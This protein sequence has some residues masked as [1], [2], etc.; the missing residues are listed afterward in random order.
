[1]ESRIFVLFLI[2]AVSLTTGCSRNKVV[3][4]SA[5][6]TVP[7][8]NPE[9]ARRDIKEPR[10]DTENFEIGAYVGYKSVEDFESNMVWGAKLAYHVSEHIFVEGTYG[11][12]DVGETSFEKLS[13]GAPLLT[14]DE[15]TMKY[16]DVSLGLNILPGE[17]FIGRSLAFNS[18]LYIVGGVGNTE[19]AGD[20]F[21]TVVFGAGYRVLAT[22]WLALNF[23]VRDHMFDSD[24]LGE[25]K[26]THNIEF[27][28]GLTLFF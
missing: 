5:D 9:V 22:D 8:I 21:F 4:N 1:M 12:T 15:R 19:F 2:V 16:Y 24:L 28:L 18:A 17:V 23:L 13:G 20:D 3:D 7:V 27:N 26:T 14:D 11:Q 6:A 25:E 10:I